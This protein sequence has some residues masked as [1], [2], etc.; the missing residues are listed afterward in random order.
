MPGTK[1]RH[2]E[3]E[4]NLSAKAKHVIIV[5]AAAVVS[6]PPHTQSKCGDRRNILRS[7]DGLLS[8]SR[9]FVARG[10]AIWVCVGRALEVLIRYNRTAAGTPSGFI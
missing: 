8:G 5:M 1:A 7:D 3:C 9:S 10:N 2:D 4:C 6:L